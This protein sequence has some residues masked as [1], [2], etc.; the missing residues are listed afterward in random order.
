MI[1]GALEDMHK[2]ESEIETS[3]FDRVMDGNMEIEAPPVEGQTRRGGKR[4][5]GSLS[6]LRDVFIPSH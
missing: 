2:A 1:G 5:V 4:K 6:L 3:S